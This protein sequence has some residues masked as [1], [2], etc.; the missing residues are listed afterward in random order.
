MFAGISSAV[1]K[2]TGKPDVV[3]ALVQA[4]LKEREKFNE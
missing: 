1:A 3:E 2:K 4:Q